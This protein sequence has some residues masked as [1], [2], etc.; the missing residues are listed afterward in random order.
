M[1]PLRQEHAGADRLVV[2]VSPRKVLPHA[3]VPCGA[4]IALASQQGRGPIAMVMLVALVIALAGAG[5]TL[6]LVARKLTL[7][8][9]REGLECPADGLVVPWADV[10]SL[11]LDAR[12]ALRIELRDGRA[13][14]AR[15][16][17]ELSIG[18][19]RRR[20]LT[21]RGA[22]VWPLGVVDRSPDEIFDAAAARFRSA[23]RDQLEAIDGGALGRE[24]RRAESGKPAFWDRE[25]RDSAGSL[26]AKLGISTTP[27]PE[28]AHR[29]ARNRRL[30]AFLATA[31]VLLILVSAVVRA[32]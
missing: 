18:R 32:L 22:L 31:T 15:Q 13:L 23:S 6:F 7:I 5:L 20:Q 24:V 19:T 9:D 26:A 10:V 11:A 4:A 14:L 27:S 30:S 1:A 12:L 16:S 2:R 29:L 21:E 28:T 17:P 3:I 8:V 25:E